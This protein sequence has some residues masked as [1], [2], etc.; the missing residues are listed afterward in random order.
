MM[1]PTPRPIPIALGTNSH[2]CAKGYVLFA[3]RI[4]LLELLRPLPTK[5][6]TG[7]YPGCVWVVLAQLISSGKK[8]WTIS[9]LKDRE[10][11]YAGTA[12]FWLRNG[13]EFSAFNIFFFPTGRLQQ[14]EQCDDNLSHVI[15]FYSDFVAASCAQKGLV[16]DHSLETA[17]GIIETRKAP[18]PNADTI[19]E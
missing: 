8:K 4:G 16:R 13:R 2:D 17:V 14:R 5:P 19:N 18:K 15:L 10:V 11:L 6:A 7:K 3:E 12:I 1:F 9:F